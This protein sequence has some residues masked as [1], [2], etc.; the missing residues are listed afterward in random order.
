MLL[1]AFRGR[2]RGERGAAAPLIAI[3]FTSTIVT[4]VLALSVDVG[5]I[6]Y[7][8][9]QLQNGADAAVMA[10]AATCAEDAAACDPDITPPDLDPLLDG[11]AADD[12]EQLDQSR[13]LGTP[14]GYT[15]NGQ[16]GQKAGSM[17]ACKTSRT[18]YENLADC[19]P[20][21]A[22]LT[23]AFP[24]VEVY[25]RTES[26]DGTTVLPSFFARA[27]AGADADASVSACARAA[28]GAPGAVTASVPLMLSVCEWQTATTSGSYYPLS[29]EGVPGYGGADQPAWPTSELTIQL[30]KKSDG[31]ACTYDGKDRPGG[32]GWAAP[33]AVQCVATLS[34]DN[35]IQVDTGKSA[36][37]ACK[38]VLDDN[39]G[40]VIALPVFDCV[41]KIQGDFTDCNSG[42]GANTY[43]HVLNWA[44]FYLAGY[45]IPSASH[46]SVRTG[47]PI[48][49][50]GNACIAGWFVKDVL[51]AHTIVPPGGSADFGLVAIKLAG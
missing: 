46:K 30:H 15:T 29:P 17:P 41:S 4:G 5:N 34:T 13:D 27:F 9:R 43:Y 33:D 36:D 6:N 51:E 11:N 45:Q 1:R 8:R 7:E 19:P 38:T 37:N 31:N 39:V 35:W 44:A 2:A 14:D 48:A 3:L 21:P 40:K 23:S 26:P 20:T 22:W 10:L 18:S 25:S 50:G 32:F 42:N 49:C 16:C 47:A 28:W 12:R 24:Y